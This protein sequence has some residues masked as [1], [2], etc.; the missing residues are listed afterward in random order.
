MEVF[1]S[2]DG[3]SLGPYTLEEVRH[4]AKD[5]ELKDG[6]FAW[7]EG[8][9]EW[10]AVSD[11]LKLAEKS[12][13]V[14][15]DNVPMPKPISV[16]KI[17]REPARPEPAAPVE[18]PESMPDI[19]TPEPVSVPSFGAPPRSSKLRPPGTVLPEPAPRP[20]PTPAPSKTGGPSAAAPAVRVAMPTP[21]TIVKESASAN[22]R[23]AHGSTPTVHVRKKPGRDYQV[24]YVRLIGLPL[25][26]LMLY[27]LLIPLVRV[28][29]EG[30]EDP[31]KYTAVQLALEKEGSSELT[32]IEMAKGVPQ[33]GRL[34]IVCALLGALLLSLYLVRS[35]LKPLGVISSN[36]LILC[37]AVI[38]VS[39]LLGAVYAK[40]QSDFAA[41]QIPG[42][43]FKMDLGFYVAM[44]VGIFGIALVVAPDYAPTKKLI[45]LYIPVI[46][47]IGLAGFVIWYGTYKTG[48]KLP[49]IMEASDSMS[50]FVEKLQEG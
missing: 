32:G 14:E 40:L 15:E 46:L 33:W 48:T 42:T 21:D 30:D 34:L 35:A 36:G 12:P 43:S 31:A 13:E 3:E 6:D 20:S 38:I 18:L 39:A 5:A 26:A 9:V 2:R 8:M 23:P 7:R 41:G 47:I 10:L 16:S 17:G 25:I 50:L 28:E 37:L 4:L 22:P 44:S 19:P 27:A 11:F 24:S 49:T 45:P 1:I 29:I